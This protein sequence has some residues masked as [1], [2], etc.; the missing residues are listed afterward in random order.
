MSPLNVDPKRS[1]ILALQRSTHVVLGGLGQELADLSLS[2]A[3]LN[4]MAVLAGHPAAPTVTQLATEVG[5]RV[6]TLSGVL[7][8]LEARG[9]VTRQMHDTDRRALRIKPTAQGRRI[10]TRVR[11]SFDALERRAFTKLPAR[12]VAGFHRTLAALVEVAEHD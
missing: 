10:A 5:S 2:S 11:R 7:D 6:T 8:R 4:V 1:G 12:A 3:E 9:Y